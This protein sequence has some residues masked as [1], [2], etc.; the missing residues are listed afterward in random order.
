MLNY[1]YD[2]FCILENKKSYKNYY[3]K[4]IALH[5]LDDIEGDVIIKM[6]NGNNI[7][8]PG[9]SF[10]AGGIYNYVID[11]IEFTNTNDFGKIMGLGISE[12]ILFD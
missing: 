11:S 3:F 12:N 4:I 2:I 1:F 10:V 9:K 5:I 8:L 6:V 7:E